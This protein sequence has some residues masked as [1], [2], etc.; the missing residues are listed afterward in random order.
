MKT[1][2]ESLPNALRSLLD[3]AF[4]DRFEDRTKDPPEPVEFDKDE[5]KIAEF[6]DEIY[7]KARGNTKR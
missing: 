1:R 6:R 4:R 7:A 2:Y 5:I 3:K